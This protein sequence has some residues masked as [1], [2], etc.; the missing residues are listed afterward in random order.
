MKQPYALVIIGAGSAGLTAVGFAAQ[1]GSRVALVEKHR[2]GSDCTWTGCVPRK[3]L[4]KAAKVAQQMRTADRYGLV[5]VEPVVDLKAVMA[6]VKSV[7]AEVYEEESPEVLRADGIDVYLA[8]AHFKDPHAIAAGEDT[9]TARR[10][11]LATGAHPFIPPING[12]ENVDYLTYESIW[13]L[14]ALPRHLL[15]IGGGPIGCEMTQAFR[16]LGAQVTLVTD[17]DR[18]LPRDEPAAAR[19]LAEVFEA[20]GISVRYDAAAERVWQDR[21]GIHLGAG[22]SEL[23]GDALLV[24]AGRQPNVDALELDR[25][26]VAYSAQGIQVD[27]YLRTSQAHIYAAGDCVGGYQF[28]H[29][30]GWQGFQAVRNALLPGT[31]KGV[32]DNVPWTTFTDPE[33]AHMGWT[34]ERARAEFG[35]AVRICHWPM[36]RVDR[37]RAEGDTTGFMNVVHKKD[38]T[39]LGVTIVAARAGEMIHEWI[40]AL[41]RGLKVGDLATTIHVY[42]TYSTAIMQAAV[43]IRVENLLSGTSGRVIRRLSR[44]MR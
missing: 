12:L 18:L 8:G 2:I 44:L 7:V 20:E 42:P 30:A 41:E 34:E 28:T 17:R 9:L 32:T 14:E 4:L 33:V 15:V 5:P 10:V 11:L 1:L 3:P 29:Y 43:H 26:G 6:H 23:V 16:R 24:A 31:S 35:D 13:N 40:V 22:G 19:V 27:E 37:A 21:D 39:L 36:A 25:A 38:G